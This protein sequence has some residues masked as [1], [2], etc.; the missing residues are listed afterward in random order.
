MVPT[1]EVKEPMYDK[2]PNLRLRL[3]AER[4]R[5]TP[6]SRPRNRQVAKIAAHHIPARERQNVGRVVFAHELAV[7]PPQL[8]VARDAD[9]QLCWSPERWQRSRNRRLR[10]SPRQYSAQKGRRHRCPDRLHHLDVDPPAPASPATRRHWR[11]L[12]PDNCPLVISTLAFLHGR[13]A[14]ALILFAAILGVWGSGGFLLRRQV[15][16]GFRSSYVL[17]IALTAL[18]GLIGLVLI[19]MTRPHELV[20]VVY[21]AFAI[22][23]LPG[24]YF[25]AARGSRVREAAFMAA[26]CWIVAIA[27]GRGILTGA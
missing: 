8:A 27:Y 1:Q 14:L 16:P 17:M 7:Q 23:F 21:G 4:L 18:Q 12:W 5:L 22:V 11:E 6:D 10:C 3:M 2:Q 25:W 24:V 9:G 19:T 26:S 20:H 15:S 13:L